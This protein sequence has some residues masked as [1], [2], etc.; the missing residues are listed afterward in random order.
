MPARLQQAGFHFEFSD[1]SAALRHV[2]G[3]P[4]AE[5]RSI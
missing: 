5:R 4:V 2:L 1:L 3:K